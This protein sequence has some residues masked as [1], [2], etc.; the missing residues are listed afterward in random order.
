MSLGSGRVTEASFPS[1]GGRC[2]DQVAARGKSSP[3]SAPEVQRGRGLTLGMLP[4][5][6]CPPGG[7]DFLLMADQMNGG[8]GF[9]DVRPTLLRYGA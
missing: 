3:G 2:L 7:T 8:Q 6:D 4:A 1:L 9:G 5:A